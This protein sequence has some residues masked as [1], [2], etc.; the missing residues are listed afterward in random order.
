[1]KSLVPGQFTT[2]TVRA[3]GGELEA[4]LSQGGNWQIKVRLANEPEWR[5]LCI[6][7]LDGRVL[8]PSA[9]AEPQA[10]VKIGPLSVDFVR[11]RIEVMG[12]EQS[13]RAREF[14]LLAV[15]ASEPGR[16]FTKDELLM[17]V[18]GHP[19][20]ASRSTRTLDSHVSSIRCKLRRAGIDGF[21]INYRGVGF[22]L[23]EGVAIKS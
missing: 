17:E 2:A 22:K 6:G 9:P 1:M 23:C 13:L 3:G 11:R 8:A 18:W 21:L 12:S 5:L 4:Q 15:L 7:H 14:D 10:Q 20:G 16:L 19:E